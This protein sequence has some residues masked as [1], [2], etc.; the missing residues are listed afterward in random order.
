MS[1]EMDSSELSLDINVLESLLMARLTLQPIVK[2]MN[3]LPNSNAFE[4][5]IEELPEG[6]TRIKE[7]TIYQLKMM[8]EKY[9]GMYETISEIHQNDTDDLME[10]IESFN[11]NESFENTA[12]HEMNV[13]RLIK[14][15]QNARNISRYL[16]TEDKPKETHNEQVY[17]DIDFIHYLIEKYS[18]LAT[19]SNSSCNVKEL[20]KAFNYIIKDKSSK[21]KVDVKS[22]KGRKVRYNIHKEMVNFLPVDHRK[23]AQLTQES[24][25]TL[26]HSLFKNVHM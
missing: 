24:R 10:K 14:R 16:F 1:E 9:V 18:S 23:Y 6:C 22:S 20:K 2:I 7:H 19:V 13:N 17:N 21:K 25:R 4:N 11:K 12:E 5:L 8:I 3:K 15:S 26:F